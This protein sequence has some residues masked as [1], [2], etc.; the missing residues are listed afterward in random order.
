MSD[1]EKGD[2]IYCL[3]HCMGMEWYFDVVVLDDDPTSYGPFKSEE[4][5]YRELH[6]I[7]EVNGLIL[8]ND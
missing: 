7:E 1:E 6:R 8:T 3:P 4:I 5:A 2:V